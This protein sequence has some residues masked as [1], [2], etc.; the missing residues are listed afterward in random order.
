MSTPLTLLPDSLLVSRSS[1]TSVYLLSPFQYPNILSYLLLRRSTV[2]SSITPLDIKNLDSDGRDPYYHHLIIKDNHTDELVAAQRLL[3]LTPQNYLTLAP[4]SY[5]EHC[6]PTFTTR[7]L[8]HH[9]SFCEIGR[10]F[11]TPNYQGLSY[12]SELIRAFI[13]IPLQLDIHHGYGLV[14]H[15]HINASPLSTLIFLESLK[16]NHGEYFTHLPPPRYAFSEPSESSEPSSPHP[17]IETISILSNQDPLFSINPVLLPYLRYCNARFLGSSIASDY[18]GIVQLL[19]Y[20]SK[21][22]VPETY[23]KRLFPPYDSSLPMNIST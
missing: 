4:Y 10:T 7:A 18:N 12:L 21:D 16:S 6:Y 19:F 23:L 2:F 22:L 15:N 5:L 3:F 13:R 1:S 9:G 20:G 14:S 8:A 17:L 11:I